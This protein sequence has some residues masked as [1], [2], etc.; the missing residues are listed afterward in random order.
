MYN[1]NTLE[2]E[3][4]FQLKKLMKTSYSSLHETFMNMQREKRAKG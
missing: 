4:K 1:L 3:R 2:Q